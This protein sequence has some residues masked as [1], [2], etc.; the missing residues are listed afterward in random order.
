MG[1]W[2]RHARSLGNVAAALRIDCWS[3]SPLTAL[4][5]T[6]L[7]EEGTARRIIEFQREE[8]AP[9]ADHFARRARAFD[10]QTQETSPHAWL[11]LPEPWRGA[12]FARACRQRGVGLLP[13]DAFAV[14]RETLAHAVR[15]N[16][17]AA[18][19]SGE[20]RQALSIMADLLNAGHLEISG[21]V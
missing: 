1:S 11:H 5:A 6:I 18:P 10:V 20:L 19:S 4:V 16:V 3:I 8:L 9:A 2:S 12:A 17:G 21:A 15:I 7:L 14:G 13:A